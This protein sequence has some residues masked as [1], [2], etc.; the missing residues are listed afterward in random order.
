MV[1]T[2]LYNQRWETGLFCLDNLVWHF[3]F[4]KVVGK[5]GTK[6]F[7]MSGSKEDKQYENIMLIIESCASAAIN[8]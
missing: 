3:I 8:I 7:K 6:Q 1:C 2:N 5:H 4:A